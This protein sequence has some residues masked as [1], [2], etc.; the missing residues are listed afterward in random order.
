MRAVSLQ[1]RAI[2]HGLESSKRLLTT[3]HTSK[4]DQGHYTRWLKYR[5]AIEPVICHL[6]AKHR[7]QHNHLKGQLGN[8]LNVVLAVAGYNLR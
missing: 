3:W 7:M 2:S 4:A 5:H 6:K 1:K 8:A